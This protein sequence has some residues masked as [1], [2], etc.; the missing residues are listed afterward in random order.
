MLQASVVGLA[1]S[2]YVG[3]ISSLLAMAPTV[4][5]EARYSRDFE[6][7]ADHFAADLL[8]RNR[9]LP[10]RLADI[11]QKLEA[12]QMATDGQSAAIMDQLGYLSS[13]PNTADR[14]RRLKQM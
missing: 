2:W 5:L 7:S 14:V 13:H 9:I 12:A 3:D 10:A 4:L 1:M 8:R 11:L 6:N